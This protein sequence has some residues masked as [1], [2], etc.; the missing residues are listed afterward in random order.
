MGRYKGELARY[1]VVS[2]RLTADEQRR[3]QA[4]A[5]DR[6]IGITAAVRMLLMVGLERMSEGGE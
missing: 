6:S 1:D 5:D 4:F 3:I 2:T